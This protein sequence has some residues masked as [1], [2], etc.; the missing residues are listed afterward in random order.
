MVMAVARARTVPAGLA[1]GLLGLM[2]LGY[3]VGTLLSPINNHVNSYG[4]NHFH[5]RLLELTLVVPLIMVWFI[6]LWGSLRFKRYA[7]SIYEAADGRALNTV[8]NGLLL[9]VSSLAIN[10]VVQVMGKLIA[11]KVGLEATTIVANYVSVTLSLV[12]FAVICRGAWRLAA[13]VEFQGVRRSQLYGLAVLVI[14]GALYAWLLAHNP[15]RLTSANPDQITPYYLPDWLLLSTIV[16]PYIVLWNLG[17]TA[18]VAVNSYRRY[19]KG[20]I[21]RNALS[22]LVA[23]LSTIILALVVLQLTNAIGPSLVHLGLSSILSLI[24]LL[25][26]VYGVGHVLVALGA[27]RLAKI[28]AA[29]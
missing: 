3:A 12:A 9:L 26:F 25:L 22:R 24:Y 17:L 18:V 23:G 28:E 16:L 7:M 13:L 4:L 8:A 27:R 19:A 10:G 5:I 1:Y 29:Y 2:A 15:D 14:M 11:E 6:A 20:I 21:Y